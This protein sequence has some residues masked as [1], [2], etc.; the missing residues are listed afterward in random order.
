MALYDKLDDTSRGF[1]AEGCQLNIYDETLSKYVL[2]MPLETVPSVVGSVNTVD[3]DV[4]TSNAIGKIKGKMS[5]DDKELTFLWHRD[6]IERAN[7]FLGK[8]NKFLSSYADGTGWKFISEYTYKPDDTG[9]KTTGT[10]TLISSSV[11]ELATLNVKDLMAKTVTIT[12]ELPS[13][14]L[15]ENTNGSKEITLTSNEA[16][17][18][19]TATS[20]NTSITATV[21]TNKLTIATTS[22]EATSGIV[23]VKATKEGFASWT[24]TVLVVVE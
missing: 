24:Y 9:D 19:Y 21:A 23:R 4:T 16:N 1:T 5:I 7:Q 14:I 20:D 6:N 10:I 18:T 17:V 13:E 15:L 12:S 11:D 8:Q 2:F 3:H 22:E